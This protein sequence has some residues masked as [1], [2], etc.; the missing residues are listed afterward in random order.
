[1]QNMLKIKFLRDNVANFYNEKKNHGTDSGFDLVVPDD[2]IIKAG[3]LSYKIPLGIACQPIEV[4][5]YDLIPRS[6]I[7]K[8]TLRLSNSIGLIDYSYTGEITAVVDNIGK[9]DYIIKAGDRLFQLVF[10]TREPIN[11]M[12]VDYL[13]KTDREAGGFGSTGK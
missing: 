8:T 13:N 7:I 12:C 4:H 9:E 1:M 10:P 6:S 5:G 2:H 11:V 3:V